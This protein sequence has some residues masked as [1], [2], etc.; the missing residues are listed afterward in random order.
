MSIEKLFLVK[1]FLG[2]GTTGPGADAAFRWLWRQ[3]SWGERNGG[4]DRGRKVPPE[5]SRAA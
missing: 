1:Y 2:L 4:V 5:W 3:R